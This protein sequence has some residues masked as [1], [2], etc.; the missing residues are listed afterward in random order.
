MNI[1]LKLFIL[2]YALLLLI[3]Y[4]FWGKSTRKRIQAL[5]HNILIRLPKIK[6]CPRY[7]T[8]GEYEDRYTKI[9][10]IKDTH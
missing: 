8:D 10:K 2:N 6:H 3:T 1:L 5:L 4:Q 7:E 9:K